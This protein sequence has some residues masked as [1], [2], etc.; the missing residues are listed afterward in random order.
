MIA[1]PCGFDGL[2]SGFERNGFCPL[3]WMRDGKDTFDVAQSF[4]DGTRHT[5]VAAWNVGFEATAR[6]QAAVDGDDERLSFSDIALREIVGVLL[7]LRIDHGA[8]AKHE[9]AIRDQ[10]RACSRARI[11]FRYTVAGRPRAR[12]YRFD[13]RRVANLDIWAARACS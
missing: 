8:N 9:L 1:N 11:D 2:C 10:T 6:K 4:L 3:V 5:A 7:T 13:P 12:C